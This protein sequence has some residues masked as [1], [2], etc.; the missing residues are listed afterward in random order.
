MTL[1]LDNTGV[2]LDPSIRNVG[3]EIPAR[4][5]LRFHMRRVML[6]V[7]I[8]LSVLAV[9]TFAL[10]GAQ[11]SVLIALAVLLL[12]ARVFALASFE[13]QI[14]I[15]VDSVIEGRNVPFEDFSDGGFSLVGEVD[16]VLAGVDL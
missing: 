9:L 16:I 11:D 4:H 15:F 5:F 10:V 6:S 12:T 1:L 14:N 3:V 2:Q 13:M 8:A 7:P